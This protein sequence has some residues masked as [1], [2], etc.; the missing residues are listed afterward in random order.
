MSKIFDCE[1]CG[2]TSCSTSYENG[3]E[4][5]CEE[6][7]TKTYYPDVWEQKKYEK[8]EKCNSCFE[9]NEELFCVD[10]CDHQFCQNCFDY[11]IKINKCICCFEEVDE[12]YEPNMEICKSCYNPYCSCN[13]FNRI[14]IDKDELFNNG[15]FI[16]FQNKV[17]HK[18]IRKVIEMVES[19]YGYKDFEDIKLD[20]ITFELDYHNSFIVSVPNKK[21]NP[22]KDKCYN[23]REQIQ[24][25][26]EFYTEE[27][28]DVK[29]LEYVKENICYFNKNLI[30]HSLKDG[31]YKDMIEYGYEEPEKVFDNDS[32][33]IC[34]EC[35]DENK[36]KKVGCCGH[37]LCYDC[38][39]HIIHS[40]NQ[41]C[42]ECRV[43]WNNEESGVD[44][45][46]YKQEDIDELCDLEDSN[47]LIEIVDVDAFINEIV[48]LEGYAGVLGYNDSDFYNDTIFKNE[49]NHQLVILVGDV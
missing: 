21:F 11:A 44:I 3:D 30:F 10:C 18:I 31:I 1:N 9:S 14:S 28:L 2:F 25:R 15:L 19:R 22:N 34:L 32:C 47:K 12:D 41:R 45:T 38:F 26:M 33:P 4:I 13:C 35:Y 20:E 27:E 7:Y 5:W 43:E 49:S 24:V 39:N 17:N 42:P 23:N 40:N 16:T 46:Y 37:T 6:C 8:M 29:T 36:E 48:M